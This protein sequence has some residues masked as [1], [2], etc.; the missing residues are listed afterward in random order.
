MAAKSII[1][2]VGAGI[3]WDIFT[4]LNTVDPF[5]DDGYPIIDDGEGG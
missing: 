5:V 3:G 4:E 2:C 1:L